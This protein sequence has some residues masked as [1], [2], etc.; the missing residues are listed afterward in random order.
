M[1]VNPRQKRKE[2]FVSGVELEEKVSE[3]AN[4]NLGCW[5]YG[6][7]QFRPWR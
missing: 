3:K 1:L 5:A 4:V 2:E 7:L 6:D